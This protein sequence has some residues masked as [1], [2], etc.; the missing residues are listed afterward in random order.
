M[1]SEQKLCDLPGFLSCFI[2]KQDG[3]QSGKWLSP[4]RT[5]RRVCGRMLA[6]WDFHYESWGQQNLFQFQPF[7]SKNHCSSDQNSITSQLNLGWPGFLLVACEASWIFFRSQAALFNI[8]RRKARS[9][10][11]RRL[12]TGQRAAPKVLQSH[13]KITKLSHI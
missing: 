1:N 8:S 2:L 10:K 11:R 4:Q 12:S 6:L 5:A 3:V 7:I 13:R 9:V